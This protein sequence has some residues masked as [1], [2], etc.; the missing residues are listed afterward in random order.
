L[1]DGKTTVPLGAASRIA[2][3]DSNDEARGF[4]F[5]GSQRPGTT[6]TPIDVATDTV[7]VNDRTSTTTTTGHRWASAAAPAGPHSTWTRR[8]SCRR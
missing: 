8:I 4:A 3:G 5:C 6:R 1:G 2:T 7:V